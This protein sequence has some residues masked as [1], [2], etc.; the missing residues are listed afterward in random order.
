MKIQPQ[1]VVTPGKQQTTNISSL[2][3]HSPHL[4][5]LNIDKQNKFLPN[6][7]GDHKK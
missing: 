7:R 3:L 2:L 5:I 1:W 4:Q 6:K